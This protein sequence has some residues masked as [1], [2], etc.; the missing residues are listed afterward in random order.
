MVW[1]RSHDWSSRGSRAIDLSHARPS[2]FY[3]LPYRGMDGNGRE[4]GEKKLDAHD[5]AHG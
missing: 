2:I 1:I 3:Y 4:K 5:A